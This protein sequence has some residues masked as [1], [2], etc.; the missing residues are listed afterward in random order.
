MDISIVTTV[1]DDSL[2]IYPTIKSVINQ[3]IFDNIEYI[4]VDASTKKKT[5]KIIAELIK[6]KNVKYIKSNDNNL[7]VGINI[8]I[9]ASKGKYIGILNAGDIYFSNNVL[10]HVLKIASNHPLTNVISGNLIYFDSHKITR[11]WRLNIKSLSR[12]DPVK[13]PHPA[14][15]I[16]KDI[17][18]QN[19]YYSSNYKICSDLDFFLKS[20]RDLSMRNIYVNKNFIF[21][22][23]GGLS[24]NLLKIPIKVFEDLSILFSHYSIFFVFFYLKKILIKFP[25]LFFIQKKKYY[26]ILL[27]RLL[28]I[29]KK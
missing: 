2:G 5:T 3:S 25:G 12:I 26:N 29:S 14:C 27:E 21:M 20:K 24:T 13:I 16:K 10:K 28:E 8:G 23:E 19:Q 17:L 18:I 4:I 9:R 1:K 11:I 22:R 7:Y 15:F 6:N